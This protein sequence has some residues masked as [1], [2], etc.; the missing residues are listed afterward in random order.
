MAVMSISGP[1]RRLR[2]RYLAVFF[3]ALLAALPSAFAK[4]E[5]LP[6]EAFSSLPAI[7][8]PIL[9]VSGKHVAYVATPN[10]KDELLIANTAIRKPILRVGDDRWDIRWFHWLSD[11]HLLVGSSTGINAEFEKAGYK[12]CGQAIQDDVTD[13]T[14]WLF[15]PGFADPNKICIVGGSYGGFAA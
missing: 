5:Q 14:Q 7:A 4:A 1:S 6:L 11:R 8:D 3:I 13:G 12:Q 9:S 2:H 15:E 10:G